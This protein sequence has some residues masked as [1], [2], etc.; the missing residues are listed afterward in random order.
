MYAYVCIKASL[1]GGTIRTCRDMHGYSSA[2]A[3]L[4]TW[5]CSLPAHL[6]LQPLRHAH[7]HAHAHMYVH[8]HMHMH[9]HMC[10]HM[11]M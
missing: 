4:H 1:T 11:H 6:G 8:V 7:V 9:M 10:M 2:A 3:C 5:G